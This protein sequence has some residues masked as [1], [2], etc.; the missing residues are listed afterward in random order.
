MKSYEECAEILKEFNQEHLLNFYNELSEE[1]K[2]NLLNQISNID[3]NLMKNLYENKDEIP[4]TNKKIENVPIIK[5]ENL[6]SIENKELFKIG[7]EIIKNKK[8][9]VCQMAGGQGTRLGHNGPKGTLIVDKITPPKSI[10]EIFADKLKEIYEKF[11]VKIKWY[12]MTSNSNDCDTKK[13]FED[14]NYFDYGKENITFF[15]QGELPLLDLNGKII[16]DRKDNIFM[17]PDGNGGVYEALRKNNILKD[18]KENNIEYLG[19]G[20]VDN[21]LLNLL[22]PIF[23]GLM[24]KGNYEV[25]TKTTTKVSPEEK[26]GVVCK[27]NG[28]PGVIEYTEITEEMANKRDE[29]GDLLFGEGYFG[30][31]IFKRDLLEKITDKLFY[32]VAFKK[33]TYIDLDGNKIEASNPNTY[34]F[35]AFIF[36]GFN[37]AENMLSLSVKRNEEFAPIKNKEGVDSV[38]TAAILYNNFKVKKEN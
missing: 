28:K 36:E 7:A 33:N 21:I 24:K 19:I 18:M 26:V 22:D 34:K 20:N 29:N 8:I 2:N 1:G 16:L 9:A 31:S 11:N 15:I 3:F 27:I 38:E 23:I 5:K 17:A 14:N 13:F 32:H 35:E 6:S 4:D 30:C 12:I 25:S 37:M 10:F